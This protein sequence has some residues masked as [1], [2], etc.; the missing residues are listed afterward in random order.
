VIGFHPMVNIYC[1]GQLRATL[2]GANWGGMHSGATPTTGFHVSGSDGSGSLW[3]VA[4]VTMHEPAGDCAIAPL[5][6]SGSTSGYC[7]AT[8]TNRSYAGNC[9]P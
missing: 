3:R 4:D 2:G 5:H 1:G 9:A 6:A 8:N 7:V